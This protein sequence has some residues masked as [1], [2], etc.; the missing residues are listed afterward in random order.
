MAARRLKNFDLGCHYYYLFRTAVSGYR[1]SHRTEPRLQPGADSLRLL[2][3]TDDR[4]RE[5]RPVNHRISVRPRSCGR[6]L[7]PRI[8]GLRRFKAYDHSSASSS[9]QDSDHEPQCSDTLPF[10][11]FR[12]PLPRDLGHAAGVEDAAARRSAAGIARFRAAIE[13]PATA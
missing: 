6:P 5:G 10:Q 9:A 4:I 12:V 13:F 3:N 1:R 7:G 11:A 8:Q 2:A